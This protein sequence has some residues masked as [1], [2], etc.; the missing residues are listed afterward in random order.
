MFS[1]AIPPEALQAAGQFAPNPTTNALVQ[2]LAK[3]ALEPR[4]P[5]RRPAT[6]SGWLLYLR[7]HWLRMPPGLLSAHLLRKALRRSPPQ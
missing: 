1:T 6:V 7:S 2:T 3:R 4:Y 5:L